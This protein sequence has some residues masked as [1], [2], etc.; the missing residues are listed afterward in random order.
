MLHSHVRKKRLF[1]GAT[2]GVSQCG[3]T[4]CALC[5]CGW[6]VKWGQYCSAL[7]CGPVY[8]AVLSIL[9]V[10]AW[11]TGVRL[12]IAIQAAVGEMFG[13]SER[14]RQWRRGMARE[15]VISLRLFSF[16]TRILNPVLSISISRWLT[17]ELLSYRQIHIVTVFMPACVCVCLWTFMD[18]CRSWRIKN[19]GMPSLCEIS[20]SSHPRSYDETLQYVHKTPNNCPCCLS[21]AFTPLHLLQPDHQNADCFPKTWFHKWKNS[22]CFPTASHMAAIACSY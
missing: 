19:N 5:V 17:K 22:I 8:A 4:T 11:L 15:S 7:T 13:E 2:S 18:E 21:A 3:T 16:M 12:V 10:S 6:V 9:S 14:W 20:I 1:T